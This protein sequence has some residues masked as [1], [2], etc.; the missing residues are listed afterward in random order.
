MSDD[1]IL[2]A[3]GSGGLLSHELVENVFLPHLGHPDGA[4]EDATEIELGARRVVMSTDSYV[5][6]P[7]VF[8]GGDIGKLAICGTVN[9]LAMRGARPLYLTAGFIIEEGLPLAELGRIVTSMAETATRAGVRVVAGDTKVVEH[10]SADRLF[11]NT[12]GVGVVPE[13]TCITAG[14]ARPGDVVLVSGAMGDHGLAIMTQREGLRFDGPLQSD[15]A[16]LN[17]LVADMLAAAGGG[18]HVL[19][20]PTRGGLA[21]ALNELAAASGVEIIIDE[22]AVPVHDAV[23][24]A[25]ELLG[26]D[27][28]YVANEGKLIAIV[29]PEAAEAVLKAMRAHPLGRE[30]AIVG[31][32]N[33]KHPGRV[34]LRTPLGT[35]RLLDML[36]GE[37]LPRIC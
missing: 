17:G 27:P 29:A 5:I 30:A 22:S 31:A 25:S 21:T 35:H 3:H 6:R 33:D 37:Q 18:I 20:D 7:I 32:V 26:L 9:D 34:V 8:P 11:I 36:A 16:P 2:L 4:L 10:G 28:L 24:A 19:R 23:R 13:G 12:A 15:C 1:V 14:G